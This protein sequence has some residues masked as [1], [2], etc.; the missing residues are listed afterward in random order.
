MSFLWKRGSHFIENVAICIVW[1][2]HTVDND[3]LCK[4]NFVKCRLCDV[5]LRYIVQIVGFLQEVA[6]NTFVTTFFQKASIYCIRLKK[7][8]REQLCRSF[9]WVISIHVFTTLS[10]LR[11]KDLNLTCKLKRS[12]ATCLN[13]DI[14][15]ILIL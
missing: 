3:D 8:F 14:S 13:N 7:T 2:R 4:P 15:I 12:R 1:I 5:T 11:D 6:F 9:N 10:S